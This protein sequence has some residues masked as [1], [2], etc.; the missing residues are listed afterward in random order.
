MRSIPYQYGERLV[1]ATESFGRI[2]RSAPADVPSASLIHVGGIDAGTVR[3]KVAAQSADALHLAARADRAQR[4]GE[5]I[6]R[7]LRSLKAALGRLGERRRQR[8]LE[9]ATV[10][11]LKGLD[12]R[13]LSDL[14]IG[15]S[16]IPSVALANGRDSTTAGLRVAHAANGLRLF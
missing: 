6:R 13:T 3:T 1:G 11:A 8:A 4:V 2:A 10:Q 15:R 12:D 14:G 5:R 16:E 9:R 7:A